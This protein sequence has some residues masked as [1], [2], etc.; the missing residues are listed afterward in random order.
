LAGALKPLFRLL[1]AVLFGNRDLK[2]QS[3]YAYEAG[4]RVQPLHQAA[5]DIAGFYNDY[6]HFVGAWPQPPFVDPSTTPPRFV[7]PIQFQNDFPNKSYGLEFSGNY[8]PMS[9]WKLSAGYTW[10]LVRSFPV[11]DPTEA[12]FRAGDNPR[13]QFQV[14]SYFSLPL[15]LAFDS[16]VYYVSSLP[17]QLVPSYTRLDTRVGWRPCRRLELSL[18]LQNMLQPRHAEFIGPSEWGQH[19]QV[20]RSTYGK[21]TWRF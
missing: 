17:A 9:F 15:G 6:R 5:F 16:S 10:L 20:P 1:T 8:T 18:G 21:V 19:A 7:V 13:H 2:A 4:Y 14:H 12:P 11:D 3:L